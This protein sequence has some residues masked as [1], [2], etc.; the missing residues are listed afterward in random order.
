MIVLSFIPASVSILNHVLGNIPFQ[1]ALGPA[2]YNCFVLFRRVAF[3]VRSRGGVSESFDGAIQSL[4][5]VTP[6]VLRVL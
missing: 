3:T 2:P 6:M 1:S 4:W 5:L